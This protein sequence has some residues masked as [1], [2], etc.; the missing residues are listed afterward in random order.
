MSS[1]GIGRMLW[2]MDDHPMCG[3]VGRAVVAL[4]MSDDNRVLQFD[5]SDGGSEVFYTAGDCCST[6]WIEHLSGVQ[7]LLGHKITGGSETSLGELPRQDNWEV[8]KAYKTTLTTEKGSFEIEYR[9]SSNGYYGGTL[10]FIKPESHDVY[11]EDGMF[12]VL[13]DF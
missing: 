8:I 10:E 3:L 9:N 7:A 11:L 4:K 1:E 13:E 5:M 12:Q 2:S 6:S